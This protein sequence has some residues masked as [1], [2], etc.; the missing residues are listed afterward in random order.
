[1]PIDE[2]G[3]YVAKPARAK[4]NRAARSRKSTSLP[5]RK[6]GEHKYRDYFQGVPMGEQ[7]PP[8][9]FPPEMADWLAEHMERVGL[10][11][12]DE[13]K[14]LAVDGKIDVRKLPKQLIKHRYRVGENQFFISPG[15]WV[16]MNEPDLEP[17]PEA[18]PDLSGVDPKVL[19]AIERGIKKA[20]LEQEKIAQAD[21]VARAAAEEAKK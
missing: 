17:A 18:D 12:V 10:V 6:D 20:R 9:S 5:K 8:S 4:Q 14:A 19:D 15:E 11:H 1:M 3:K 21:P 13:L 2:S 16:G 7:M